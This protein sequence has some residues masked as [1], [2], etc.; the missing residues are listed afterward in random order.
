MAERLLKI[1][2]V[3]RFLNM[4]PKSAYLLIEAGAL[5]HFRIRRSIRVSET[6][7]ESFLKK[8]EVPARPPVEMQR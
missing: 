8:N 4:K 5:A 7:L 2:E 1:P 3:A 6:Q